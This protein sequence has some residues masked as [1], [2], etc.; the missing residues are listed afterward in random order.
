VE[1]NMNATPALLLAAATEL[2]PEKPAM[3]AAALAQ[4]TTTA[5]TTTA[6]SARLGGHLERL[7]EI[8]EIQADGKQPRRRRDGTEAQQPRRRLEQDARRSAVDFYQQTVQGGGTLKTAAEQLWLCPRTLRQWDYDY[9]SWP[10]AAASLGRPPVQ[11]ETAQRAALLVWLERE[12]PQVG[13][14]RLRREFPLLARAE[15]ADLLH[16][17]RCQWRQEQHRSVRVLHW[18]VP[19]RVWAIDFAE[20]SLLKATCS[21]PPIDQR[22]PYLLA[23]RDL[24]SGYQLAWLPVEQAD[25][26]CTQALLARLFAQHGAPLILKSDNGPP[27][28]AEDTKAFVEDAGVFCLFSPPAC[29]GY[30]GSIEAAIGSLKRRTQQQAERRH[31]PGMWTSADVEAARTQANA[32]HPPRLNGRTPA[33]VWEARSAISAVERL[34]FAF[35]T[36]C[37]RERA[38]KELGLDVEA[39]LNHWDEGKVDRKAIERAL[40][41][42][43]YLLFTGRRIPLTVRPGKVTSMG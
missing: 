13:V 25:A 37:Q 34:R 28:R 4:D 29:P 23:V 39:C 1:E 31:H 21:L 6:S 9:R 27:F 24:A 19:G 26:A 12:G 3:P 36:E 15:L 30:N 35:T 10:V 20:P 40:V 17:Y 2:I 41:E 43:D 22:Y 7:Q 8:I 42:H 33:A 11:A 32:G 5:N 18:Q 16:S 14:P 38:R